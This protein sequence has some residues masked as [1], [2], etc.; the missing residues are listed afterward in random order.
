[1][2][3]K[4]KNRED[5]AHING[6]NLVDKYLLSQPTSSARLTRYPESYAW[7]TWERA[8]SVYDDDLTWARSCSINELREITGSYWAA[9]RWKINF[10][11]AASERINTWAYRWLASMWSN[12]LSIIAPNRNLVRYDGHDDGTHIRRLA[13]WKELELGNPFEEDNDLPDGEALQ[14]EVAD[15][16]IGRNVFRENFLGT[17]EGIAASVAMGAIQKHSKIK[18]RNQAIR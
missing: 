13:R 7:A 3:D 15:R 17:C 11:D 12:N 1:M 10:A 2:L 5:I 16:W 4:F 18:E 8:W 14:D 6:Y 9:A